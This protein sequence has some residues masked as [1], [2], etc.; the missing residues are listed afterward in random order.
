MASKTVTSPAGDKIEIV[1]DADW[2]IL[3]GTTEKSLRVWNAGAKRYIIAALWNGGEVADPKSGRATLMLWDR[4]RE[5]FGSDIKIGKSTAFSGW[6]TDA[7][8]EPSIE[9]KTN[10]K[11]TQLIKLIALPETWYDFLRKDEADRERDK[12]ARESA[13]RKA[14]R[15]RQRKEAEANAVE[16][17]V[18]ATETPS[19]DLEDRVTDD[20]FENIIRDMQLDAPTVYDDPQPVLEISIASQVA[21]SLLTTV[22]EI[23]SAGSASSVDEKVRKLQGDLADAMNKLASRLEDNDRLRRQLRQA[24]DEITALRHE[25][26]GLRSRLRATEANLTAALKGDAV[27]AINGEIQ[28]RMESIMRV[29]PKAKGDE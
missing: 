18:V 20:D 23:I 7:L 10:G 4:M 15:E 28:R 16:A 24:G 3:T 6:A 25:R 5:A 2:I 17:E 21:M 27:Q 22:V 12:R 13:E 11:R 19:P 14:E 8:N 9:R 1:P 26:D 29:S